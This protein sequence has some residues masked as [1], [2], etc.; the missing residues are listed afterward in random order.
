MKV[1][2]RLFAAARQLAGRDLLEVEVDEPAT[3]ARVRRQMAADLPALAQI[4]PHVLFAV[5]SE[6]VGEHQVLLAD[7]DVACIPPVSGG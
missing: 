5:G 3:V 2:I 1:R 6:Y 7:S 4:L